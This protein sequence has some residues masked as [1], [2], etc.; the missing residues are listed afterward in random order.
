MR[1]LVGTAG[2]PSLA[3]LHTGWTFCVITG[4]T[5]PCP[6]AVAVN[7]DN[8][9]T[10]A[11]HPVDVEQGGVADVAHLADTLHCTFPCDVDIGRHQGHGL[12]LLFYKLAETV[13]NIGD[14]VFSHIYIQLG[15]KHCK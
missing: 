4:I 10:L 8:E 15:V 11:A 5:T 2:Q 14:H 7:A 3:A 1:L 9:A 12:L 13:S 6:H